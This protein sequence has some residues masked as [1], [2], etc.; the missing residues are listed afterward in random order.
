MYV[1]RNLV[2][3]FGLLISM[4]SANIAFGNNSTKL[5]DQTSPNKAVASEQLVERVNINSADAT[6]L[7]KIKGF[8]KKKAQAVVEFREKNGAFK[9]VEDLLKVKSRGLNK[10]WLDKISKFLMV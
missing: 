1:L 6:A 9:S 7:Q 3:I 4:V 2:V 8:G 5:L 10:K